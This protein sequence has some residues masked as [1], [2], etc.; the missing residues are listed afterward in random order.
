[1]SVVSQRVAA[2]L[3]REQR[4]LTETLVAR[5]DPLGFQGGLRKSA[6]QSLRVA[7]SASVSIPEFKRVPAAGGD[8]PG[9]V[10]VDDSAVASGAGAQ[11]PSS[12]DAVPPST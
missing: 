7:T 6:R 12:A 11:A 2:P 8:P 5:Q 9:V 10:V 4:S 3:D 1:M